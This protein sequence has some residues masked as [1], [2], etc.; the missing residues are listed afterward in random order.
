MHFTGTVY[1]DFE[2][3]DNWRIYTLLL[4]A[5]RD[6]AV[7]VD[8]EWEAFTTREVEDGSSQV[9]GLA[10][11]A[12]VRAIFAEQHERFVRAMLTLVYQEQDEAGDD[13]TLAVAA[14]VAGI[15]AAAVLDS[16][17]DPGMRLLAASV[18]SARD[19]GVSGVPSIE[20][21]GPPL[22]IKTSGAA[23]YGDAVARLRL[24]D[25]MIGD[26]GIWVMAKPD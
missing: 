22:L 6:R 5:S 17:D 19:R 4:K 1:F 7:S 24:I 9:R 2:S 11:C 16:V 23:N 8:V 14:K 13:K 10:A 21:Q 15:D 26:D 12:A 25:R 20:R 3:Y 18:D